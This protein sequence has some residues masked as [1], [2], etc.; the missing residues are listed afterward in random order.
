METK[1]VIVTSSHGNWIMDENGRVL[2]VT[3]FHEQDENILSID[4]FDVEEYKHR[5]NCH[6][7]PD[8]IDILDLG[9]W[10]SPE[11]GRASYEQPAFDWKQLMSEIRIQNR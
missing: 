1:L 6:L 9:Y 5:N 10:Y 3:V 2:D 7:L 11:E 4:K 8:T